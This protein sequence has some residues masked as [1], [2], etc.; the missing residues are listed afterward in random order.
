MQG[1]EGGL[2]VTADD[3][4]FLKL[5]RHPAASASQCYRAYIGKQNPSL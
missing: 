5:F 1:E 4:G 2:L 3:N